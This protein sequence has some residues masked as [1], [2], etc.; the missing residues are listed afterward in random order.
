MLLLFCTDG[1]C[2]EKRSGGRCSHPAAARGSQRH[3]EALM[4]TFLF[5]TAMAAKA[6]LSKKQVNQRKY[7]A[8]VKS[9]R[10]RAKASPGGKG[11]IKSRP[12][13]TTLRKKLG[14]K[15]T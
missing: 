8:G 3:A 6:K 9:I 13:A 10:K 14:L 4:S 7:A 2:V 11:R 15:S 12:A 1:P 5:G